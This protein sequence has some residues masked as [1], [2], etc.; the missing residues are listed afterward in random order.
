MCIH[1]SFSQT[2]AL[3]TAVSKLSSKARGEQDCRQNDALLSSSEDVS[4]VHFCIAFFK[5]EQYWL[6]TEPCKKK[7]CCGAVPETHETYAEMS[8]FN[9]EATNSNTFFVIEE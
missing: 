7:A 4:D 9:C 3:P 8:S 5:E 2:T 6:T 1:A